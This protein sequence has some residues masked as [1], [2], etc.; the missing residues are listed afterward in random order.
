MTP[1]SFSGFIWIWSGVLG[2]IYD[3]LAVDET[4]RFSA[5]GAFI[6]RSK[7]ERDLR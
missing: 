3:N 1:R 2:E 7:G 6:V 5:L 4:V